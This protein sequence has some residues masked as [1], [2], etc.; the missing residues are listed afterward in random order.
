MFFL[1]NQNYVEKY[2]PIVIFMNKFK[3]ENK[4]DAIFVVFIGQLFVSFFVQIGNFLQKNTKI[5]DFWGLYDMIILVC[6]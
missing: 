2:N 3:Y 4:T 1:H 5:I 6:N